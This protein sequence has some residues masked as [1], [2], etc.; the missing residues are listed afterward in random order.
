MLTENIRGK[1]EQ[2][3]LIIGRFQPLHLGHLHAIQKTLENFDFLI[4][5]VGSS[6]AAGTKRNPF[7]YEE[8]REML[9][10]SLPRKYQGKYKIISLPDQFN[11]QRWRDYCLNQEKF[12]LVISGSNW[13]ARCFKN[14]KPLQEPDFLK[15]EEYK[16][17]KIR[18]KIA[19]GEKWEN[20]VP[21]G[22][23]AVMRKVNGEER[24]KK[25]NSLS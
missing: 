19:K 11:D 21:E 25:L 23:L 8:R 20:L 16:A 14:Y 18:K 12:D 13:V 10:R 3:P 17:S 6:Q 7:S 22:T 15:P 5:G 9:E 4:I 2:I 1:L 24:I